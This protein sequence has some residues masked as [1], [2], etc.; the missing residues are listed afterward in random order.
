MS[1]E[2]THKLMGFYMEVLV[3]GV[4]LQYMVS[5]SL[6]SVHGFCFFKLFP[7]GCIGL[8]SNFS[9]Q[10][11][12][13]SIKGAGFLKQSSFFF[14]AYFFWFSLTLHTYHVSGWTC[15]TPCYGLGDGT[16]QWLLD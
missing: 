3:L 15:C 4:I 9:L 6:T 5:A 12:F 16:R 10:H 2:N 8:T 7:V 1:L 14:R 11:Y 13:L